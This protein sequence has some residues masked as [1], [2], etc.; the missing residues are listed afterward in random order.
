MQVLFSIIIPSYNRS[1]IL[2]QAIKSVLNQSYPNW[3]LFI[4]DD[5]SIDGTWA[6]MNDYSDDRIHYLHKEN[7]GVCSARNYGVHSS[8]GDYIVF[9]D[10]D[11]TVRSYGLGSSKS[12]SICC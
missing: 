4:V 9:L 6:L 2:P 1:H 3:E 10:S 8:K 11:D 7:G 12:R 5:G